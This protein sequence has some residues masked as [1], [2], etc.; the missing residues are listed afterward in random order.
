MHG[1]S[2]RGR[3]GSAAKPGAKG[4][5]ATAER[6]HHEVPL[7]GT[8]RSLPIKRHRDGVRRFIDRVTDPAG[9]LQCGMRRISARRRSAGGL[10]AAMALLALA[11]P[12][13]AAGRSA[14]MHLKTQGALPTS[15]GCLGR[16]ATAWSD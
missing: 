7:T 16:F 9:L 10:A 3:E 12:D 8:H 5:G 2:W 15:P 1:H 4:R 14:G 6:G 11:A 13:P